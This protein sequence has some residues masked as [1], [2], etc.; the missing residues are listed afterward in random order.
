MTIK[1]SK[2]VK[3]N[4]VNPL[5]IV[6]NKVNGYF[7]EINGSKYLTLVPTNKNKEKIKKYEELWIKI[8]DLIRS[9]TRNSDEKYMKIKFSSDDELSV[10]KTIEIP[11]MTVVVTAIF[12]ENNKYYQEVFLDEY[13]NDEY[14]SQII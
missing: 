5:H 11:A 7:Q 10:N 12:L 13:L 2:Y 9:I 14:K 1:D 4:S 8:R 6:F 3:I